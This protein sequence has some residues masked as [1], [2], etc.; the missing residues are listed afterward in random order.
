L[1]K[2]ENNVQ[3]AESVGAVKGTF[4]KLFFAAQTPK[5]YFKFFL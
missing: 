1:G 2:S 5:Q 4:T 3:N